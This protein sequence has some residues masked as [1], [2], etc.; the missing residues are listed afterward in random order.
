MP[1]KHKHIILEQ[2]LIEEAKKYVGK[3]TDTE[4]IIYALKYL[5]EEAKINKLLK[6]SK[7]KTKIEKVY[8]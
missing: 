4:V 3:N 5:A 7:G 8:S 1:L 2:G 6:K